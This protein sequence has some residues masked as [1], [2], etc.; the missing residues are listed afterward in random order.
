MGAVGKIIGTVAMLAVAVAAPYLAPAIG[1]FLGFTGFLATAIGSIVLAAGVLAI[2]TLMRPSAPTLDAGRV[3][4]RIAEPERW[5]N[6]G[7]A[8]QGGAVL[9]AEFDSAGNLW[10]LVVHS[11][12][13]LVNALQYYLDDEPVSLSGNTVTN[14]EFR[15][16]SNKDKD[17]ATVDGEGTGYV[18][19]WTTTYSPSDPT[20]PAI[21]AFKAA[22]PLWTN[23]HKLVGT[24]YSVVKMSA[25]AVEHRYKIYKWRGPLGLG[26]PAVSIVG[27]WS[28]PYDPRTDTNAFTRN[29]V[30]IWAWF[31]TQ[32]YGRNKSVDSINWDKVAEQADI[33]DQMVTGISGSH[34]RYQCG[35]GAPESKERIAAEQEIMLSC[36]GQL[37]FDDDGKC[38]LRVGHYTA[39][40]LSL[41]RNR[42]IV[43][44]ESVEATNGESETQ[45]VIVRYTD[46]DS[47]YIAQP[48][49]PWYNPLYYVHGEAA[50]FLVV[51]ILTCQ[52]HN[53]AMRL[54]KGIGMRSQP[55]HKVVPTAGLRGLKARQERIVNL[56]YDNT[57]AGDYEIV[58]PVEVDEIGVFCGFGAVP[59]DEDRW[60]L[61][62]GEEKAKGTSATGPSAPSIDAPVV[63][64]VAYRNGRIEAA[65]DAPTRDD[66]FYRFQYIAE[67]DL[68]SDEWLEMTV[69]MG[70]Q[71]AYS[72]AL[73]PGIEYLVH[74]RTVTSGGRVSE[75]SD[76]PTE[77]GYSLS[78]GGALQQA[79]YNS[80]ILEVAQ[81][82]AVVTIASDGTLTIDDHTRR[83][84]DGHVDV[85]VT[86]D[87][88][89]TGL[90][91]GDERAIAYD[92]INRVGGSVTYNLYDDDA[93][94]H[95]TLTNPG[96]HYVGYF[97]V[98]SSGS[99]GGGG[100]GVP[101][102]GGF[103]VT[104]DTPILMANVNRDGR[105]ME[106]VA[107]DL[108]VGDWLWTQ[109]DPDASPSLKWGAYQV[110]AISFA[111]EPVYRADG[112]PR[113][114]AQ[115]RFWIDGQWRTMETLGEPDGT[116]TVAKI[117]VR[118]AHTYIS[119]GVLSH[120]VKPLE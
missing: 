105:G 93:E 77:L 17:P 100:G 7:I 65:F 52:D 46:P 68:A 10:Y 45:G 50:Q 57:F 8:R 60:T 76:P 42:D 44:L 32:R 18:Q 119:A 53:Q 95:A 62:E 14:K 80:Y 35:F 54:A 36:D 19:I 78:A 26:E 2:Q 111:N 98:P 49:A 63:T 109:Y 75:W 59:V 118:D 104:T 37:V 71:I 40:T 97:V 112:L 55:L 15:L 1:Q 6:A 90:S 108:K 74:Y 30:L 110:E 23:D 20:P 25:L 115:H 64:S 39:P 70:A 12:S 92:D 51:D 96:R 61:L 43:A 24:T 29:P 99:S 87:V 31:R 34:V 47:K 22:N 28:L 48:S 66:V 13:I 84:N 73:P 85:A 79:V 102:G 33:C 114:T 56:N 86:G 113:A 117:T 82:V 69:D 107:G 116:A 94:A 38:W 120:N 72:D 58:T 11:D 89:A 67:A 81:G 5:L 27:E 21:A 9:Y 101:G 88:I 106:K 4:V 83:Y 103:C 16:K 41:N 91:I 3:N